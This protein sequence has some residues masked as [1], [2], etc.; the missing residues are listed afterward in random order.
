MV[1]IGIKFLK[2][3]DASHKQV[4]AWFLKIVSS[5]YVSILVYACLCV[6][7]HVCTCVHVRVCLSE[8]ININSQLHDINFALLVKQV[9]HDFS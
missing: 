3:V 5:V 2:Q 7:V 4:L 1:T 9:L 6:C 8:G